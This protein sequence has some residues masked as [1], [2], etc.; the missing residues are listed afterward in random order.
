MRSRRR[1]CAQNCPKQKVVRGLSLCGSVVPLR[2]GVRRNSRASKMR[3]HLSCIP[4]IP[5]P[6]FHDA[7]VLSG[8]SSTPSLRCEGGFQRPPEGKD[9]NND[10]TPTFLLAS[11]QCATDMGA[12]PPG[13]VPCRRLRPC[14]AQ[15]NSAASSISNGNQP[16]TP[17]WGWESK[18][19]PGASCFGS[20]RAVI[21]GP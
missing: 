16:C 18:A 19:Q 9:S 6:R 17:C 13:T 15:G 2:A 10:R 11:A 5:S 21:P 1:L 3:C 14:E 7:S 8:A 20:S 4:S 12:H